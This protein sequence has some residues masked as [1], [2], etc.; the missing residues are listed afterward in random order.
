V[1]PVRVE[2][3][4]VVRHSRHFGIRDRPGGVMT[5]A[6]TR[7]IDSCSRRPKGAANLCPTGS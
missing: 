2:I 7:A 5:L 1:A 4:S 3:A 6:V